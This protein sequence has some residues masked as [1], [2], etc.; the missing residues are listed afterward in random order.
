MENGWQMRGGLKLPILSSSSSS[1]VTSSLEQIQFQEAR[2]QVIVAQR[3]D[4]S[5]V[6]FGFA[7][8][9]SLE[10]LS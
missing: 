6:K 7:C 2:N 9:I 5:C 1:R 3:L 8:S 4:V 10:I